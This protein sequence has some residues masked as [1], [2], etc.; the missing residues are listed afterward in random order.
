VIGILRPAELPL[1]MTMIAKLTPL[2]KDSKMSSA[3]KPEIFNDLGLNF[4]FL[5]PI[6]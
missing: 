2:M 5:V 1:E 3:Q 4:S 6:G